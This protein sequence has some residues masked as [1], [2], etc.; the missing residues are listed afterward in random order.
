MPFELKSETK[1]LGGIKF[2]VTQF[3]AM[4]A[5]EVMVSLQRMSAGMSPNAQLT[6]VAHQAMASADPAA[7]QKMILDVLQC[8][9]AL[10][11]APELKLM[12]LG[13]KKNIDLVFTG[14]LKLLFDVMAFAIEVNYG[15]FKEG[16]EESAPQAQTPSQ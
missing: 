12:N 1:E 7:T 6:Q 3:P 15:D 2:T 9:T 16:S 4:K 10:V 13:E 11:E 14:R 8:T 5:I